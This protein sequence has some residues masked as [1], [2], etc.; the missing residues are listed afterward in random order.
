MSL[1]I[2][3]INY[4]I[5]SSKDDGTT[6][7]G[8][9]GATY[10]SYKVFLFLSVLGGFFALDHLY[11]RSPLT[12]LGKIIVNMLFFGVWWLYDASQAVFNTEVVKVFGLGIPGMGPQGIAAGVLGNEVPDQKHMAFFFYGIALFFGGLLGIDSFLVGD[13]QSGFIRLISTLTIIFSFISIFWWF[14]NIFYFIFDT[15]SVVDTYPD[16]FGAPSTGGVFSYFSKYL[17]SKFPFLQPII[18]TVG[19]VTKVATTALGSVGEIASKGI[20]LAD[21]TRQSVEETAKAATTALSIAPWA[22]SF[23]HEVTAPAVKKAVEQT[24]GEIV[25]EG[26]GA[27]TYV[28]LMTIAL[29]AVSG[30]VRTYL[31]SNK[32]AK[33]PL[34]D[35][36]PPEPRVL[37][38][39]DQEK[40]S[41]AT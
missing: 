26:S 4:W 3:Q 24:G 2:S 20:D 23:P 21:K 15:K 19:T 14:Y 13:H 1:G 8:G 17:V 37:R 41:R 25:G 22:V 35:D 40:S 32:N 29:I 27:L 30:F 12:F 16:Y 28:F 31:R 34:Q 11:L 5:A 6:K 36:A 18:G 33:P 39:P 38:K 10:L 9:P 7:E